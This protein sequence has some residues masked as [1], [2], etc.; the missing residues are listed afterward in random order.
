M[1]KLS[2]IFNE[3]FITMTVGLLFITVIFF[4]FIQVH[5]SAPGFE[6][7]DFIMPFLLLIFLSKWKSYPSK[8]IYFFIALFGTYILLTIAINGRLGQ[9]RDYFEIFKLIKFAAVIGLFTM[10]SYNGFLKKWIKPIFVGLV[11][12]NL[13]HYFD[14]FNFNEFLGKYYQ[15]GQR[16]PSFGFN[17]IGQPTYKRMLGF[18][19]NPN[20]NALIFLFFTAFFI[21]EIGK[22]LSLKSLAWFFTAVLMVFLCQSRT[23]LV[24]LVVITIVHCL[25]IIKSESKKVMTIAAAILIGFGFSAIIT[26]LSVPTKSQFEDG[27]SENSNLPDSL[28]DP[29]GVAHSTDSLR[30]DSSL[31]ND[32]INSFK[33]ST[34]K[35]KKASHQDMTYIETLLDGSAF[36]TNSVGAR[37]EIWGHLWGM[38]KK[39]PIIG[40]GPYKE[41]FYDNDLYSESEY[42]AITWRYGFIGLGIF[43]GLLLFILRLGVKSFN[44]NVGRILTLCTVIIILASVTNNPFSHKTIM[45]LYGISIGLFFNYKKSLNKG[46]NEQAEKLEENY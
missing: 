15:A 34:G 41:Y 43:V 24:I 23:G 35:M 27:L 10:V 17:S 30:A 22:K 11:L 2:N 44:T 32:Y 25:P 45:V 46:K 12:F 3:K 28:V 33:D 16:V 39:K 20:N 7:I 38:I 36:A 42:V 40:H 18:P 4:P 9:I 13:I 19:C 1:Q 37:I 5:S 29:F 26:R 14:L 6:V 21:P 31:M 8:K